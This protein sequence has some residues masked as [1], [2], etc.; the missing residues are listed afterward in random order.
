MIVLRLLTAQPLKPFFLA[1][2]FSWV[3]EDR[4]GNGRVN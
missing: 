4:P 2:S 3:S 1:A